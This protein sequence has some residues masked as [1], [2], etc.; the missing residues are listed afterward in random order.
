MNTTV[1]KLSAYQ[2]KKIRRVSA[3]ILAAAVTGLLS[4]LVADTLKVITEHYEELFLESIVHNKW[5]ILV[6]PFAGLA[7]IYILRRF[8][9]RNKTNKGIKEVMDTIN[10]DAHLLPAY[11]IPSHYFNGFLTVIFGGSTGIEVSTVVSTA[12]IGALSSRKAKFLKKYR[13][14][15]I[16][17]GLAAGLTALF[18]APFAGFLFAYE[19]FTKR[20]SKLHHLSV[21]TAILTAWLLTHFLFYKPLFEFKIS[22][23]Q[24][25]AIPYMLLLAV[26]AGFSAAYLTKCVLFAKKLFG[27]IQ[28]DVL[29]IVLGSLVISALIFLFPSLYG[30]G[31]SGIKHALAA[32]P[33]T[34]LTLFLPLLL[35][36]L[37]KPVATSV[38]LGAGGDGGVFAPSLF[39]GAFLGLLVCNVLNHYF[40][41]GLI[42]VNFV[43]IGMA[44]VLSGSIHAPFTAIFLACA[45]SESYV[46]FLPIVAACLVARW[47]AARLIPYSVYT[48]QPGVN[49][50]R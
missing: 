19:V 23:W 15:L 17:A 30:E 38:T 31:Y 2:N 44:A 39:I 29:R 40:G 47:V 7:M 10:K 20:R 37:L 41:L 1:M 16:C 25:K 24:L 34:S 36:L 6:L 14:D 26:L 45:I 13:T 21:A 5:L 48:Y 4:A 49:M 46:L 11:K 50:I 22:G 12:A 35:V 18:N 32:A 8:L 9:F 43:V 33:Q 42:P 27:S 28:H 3:V